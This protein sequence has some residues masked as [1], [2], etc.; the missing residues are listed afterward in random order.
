MPEALLESPCFPN[1]VS[2]KSGIAHL[3]VEC[4]R[5]FHFIREYLVYFFLSFYVFKSRFS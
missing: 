5:D 1:D 2:Q 4:S 3:F